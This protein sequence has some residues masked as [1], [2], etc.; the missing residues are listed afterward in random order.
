MIETKKIEYIAKP[1]L[2]YYLNPLKKALGIFLIIV[3]VIGLFLPILQGLL[4]I[5]LGL[6]LV[7]YTKQEIK[8]LAKK[9]LGR[10]GFSKY[11]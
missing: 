1:G 4:F 6:L 5:F 7:G 3:G 11:L 8:D 10:F 2:R 9:Y